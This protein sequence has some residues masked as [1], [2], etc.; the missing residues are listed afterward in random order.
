MRLKGSY[1]VEAAIII[2]IYIF[3]MT[4]A[5]R[6]GIKL[7]QEITSQTEYEIVEDMWLVDDF[8]RYKLIQEVI[9]NE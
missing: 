6:A 5:M 9:K 1:M 8:Y 7:Y 4:I 3:I 2:P